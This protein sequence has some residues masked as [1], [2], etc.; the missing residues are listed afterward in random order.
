MT[1][2]AAHYS[3]LQELKVEVLAMSVDSVYAHKTWQEQELSKM[4]EGGIPY[5][6]LSEKGGKVGEL[7]GVYD[8]DSGIDIRGQFIIDPDGIIQAV[9]ILNAPVG[10][11]IEELIRQIKAFQC[12]RESGG[13]EAIPAGW[14]PGKKT[15]TPGPDLVCNVCKEWDSD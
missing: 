8:N 10:R 5:H 1:A 15:L 12:V 13:K 2:V 3:A 11:N 9:E 6:M 4:V 14:Q 7:Y